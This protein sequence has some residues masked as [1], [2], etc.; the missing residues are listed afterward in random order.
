MM[1]KDNKKYILVVGSRSFCDYKYAA[2]ILDKVA[3][4][5]KDIVIVSGGADGADALAKRYAAERDFEYV[6]FPADW[7]TYGKSAGYIRNEEMH[8]YIAQFKTRKVIAFWDGVSKGT[9]HSFKLAEKYNNEI[10]VI[11][12][13]K[14]CK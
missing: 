13:G 2:H 9:A 8:K 14:A 3:N 4:S 11:K 6:E 7:K 12:V 10:H 5:H 1:E